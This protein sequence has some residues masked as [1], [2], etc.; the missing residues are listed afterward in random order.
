MCD[1]DRV[2]L[3]GVLHRCLPPVQTLDGSLRRKKL[4]TDSDK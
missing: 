3:V 1:H 2:R 4:H